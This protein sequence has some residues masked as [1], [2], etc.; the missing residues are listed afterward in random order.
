M[1]LPHGSS[2]LQTKDETAMQPMIR[3]STATDFPVDLR[4]LALRALMVLAAA[5]LLLLPAT[6]EAQDPPPA[7]ELIDRYV[8]LIGGEELFSSTGSHTTGSISMPAMGLQGTFEIYQSP[9]DQMVM[10]MEIPGVGE[11]LQGY[12]GEVGWSMNPIMGPQLM[13]GAELDQTREQAVI[14]ASL[15]D[16]SVIPGR[17]TIGQ[18]EY[19]GEACWEVQLTWNSGRESTD[20]YS[21]ESGLL[22][23]SEMTQAS[24]MGEVQATTIYQDYEEFEGRLLPTRMIQRSAGQ[25]QILTMDHVEYREIDPAQFELPDAIRTLLDG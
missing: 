1:T 13:E 21:I 18:S 23:A 12:D 17:E 16:E 19:E 14:A 6:L 8:E 3:H 2:L 9:P 4:P 22:I 5:L 24:T 11:I 20:C 7:D 25:E 10:H 15:R